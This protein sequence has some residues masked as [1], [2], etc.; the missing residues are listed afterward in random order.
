MRMTVPSRT[1]LHRR[2][3]GGANTM[4]VEPCS[5]QP[6]SSPLLNGRVAGDRRGAAIVHVQ[7]DIEE[8]QADAGDQ[9]R[10]HRHQR[11]EVAALASRVR[12]TARSFLQ[13]SRSTR[14]SAIGLTFQVSPEM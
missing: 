9:D 10:R 6:S 2:N 5:N 1:S 8:V 12:I 3:P 14:L 11:D 13:N 4:I 7:H